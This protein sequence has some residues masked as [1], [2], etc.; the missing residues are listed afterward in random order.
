[1]I[2]IV[3]GR[4]IITVGHCGD[5]TSSVELDR[6]N[7]ELIANTRS[8]VCTTNESWNPILRRGCEVRR[9]PRFNMMRDGSGD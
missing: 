6:V 2:I 5:P 1:M 3:A 7:A 9:Q 4:V 8:V